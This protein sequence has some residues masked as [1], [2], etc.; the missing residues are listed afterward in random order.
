[1][2]V[3]VFVFVF[4]FFFF[5][6]CCFFGFF[7]SVCLFVLFCFCF[8]LFCFVLLFFFVRV[9]YFIFP[10]TCAF[11]ICYLNTF[12][13][14]I[15][16]Y[17]S[18]WMSAFFYHTASVFISCITCGFLLN[19]AKPLYLEV[20]CEGVYPVGEGITIGALNWLSNC[21]GLTFLFVMM[22]PDIGKYFK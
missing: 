3:F 5:F 1:M 7:L 4:V 18:T 2:F 6:C 16:I 21:I 10:K 22:I 14:K 15:V 11:I 8:V 19:A 20:I 12:V 9:F 13:F 17:A